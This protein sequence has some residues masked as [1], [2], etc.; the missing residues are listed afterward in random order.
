ML[1]RLCF[2]RA[3]ATLM[4]YPFR[5]DAVVFSL[6]SEIAALFQLKSSDVENDFLKLQTK[7]ELKSNAH[8]QF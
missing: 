6:A 3:I 7:I 4:C 2:T 1:S 8:V 5:E